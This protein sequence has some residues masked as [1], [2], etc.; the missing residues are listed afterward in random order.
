M[1]ALTKVI[2][3]AVIVL[4]CVGMTA[5]ATLN[6]SKVGE[7]VSSPKADKAA[8][9]VELVVATLADSFTVMVGD[10]AADLDRAKLARQVR[11]ASAVLT[12]ARKT[13]DARKGGVSALVGEAF[14][15][16]AQALPADASTS[17]RLAVA[18]A[19][20]GLRI[21]AATLDGVGLPAEPSPDLVAARKNADT[22]IGRL[23]A[24]LPSPGT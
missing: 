5:C 2:A 17:A 7:A 6:T 8:I 4:V 1:E 23:R 13:F 19:F 16:V 12:S 24:Q 9:G 20:T 3:W 22:A 14:D 10:P 11:D 18:S 21:Y 15:L